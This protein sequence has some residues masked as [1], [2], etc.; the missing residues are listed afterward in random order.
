MAKGETISLDTFNDDW[1][2]EEEEEEIDEGKLREIKEQHPHATNVLYIRNIHYDVTDSDLFSLFEK[3]GICPEDIVLVKEESGKFTGNAVVQFGSVDDT[4]LSFMKI[5]GQKLFGR[6]VS[7]SENKDFRRGFSGGPRSGGG[8]F[9]SRDSKPMV[10][11]ADVRKSG[12]REGRGDAFKSTGHSQGYRES[13]GFSGDRERDRDRPRRERPAPMGFSRSSMRSSDDI[14]KARREVEEKEK[15]RIHERERRRM[16][17][18]PLPSFSRDQMKSAKDVEEEKAKHDKPFKKDS[19]SIR[20][21]SSVHKKKDD[22]RQ[23]KRESTNPFEAL[24][25]K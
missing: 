20:K 24:R 11:F 12:P 5:D 2:E 21:S 17:R 3:N 1:D 9:G 23:P 15:K 22:K 4:Y 13:R 7:L 18:Q 10:N 16:E 19:K 14:E 8:G 25:G 6:E